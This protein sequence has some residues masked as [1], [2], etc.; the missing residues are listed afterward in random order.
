MLIFELMSTRCRDKVEDVNELLV[1]L[2]RERFGEAVRRHL[3][4][5]NPTDTDMPLFY[6]L[7]KPMVMDIN[8]FQLC[9]KR[10]LFSLQ[11]GDC[12]HVVA[13]YRC[14]AIF[15][16]IQPYV[17]EQSPPPKVVLSRVTESQ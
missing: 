8:V 13:K 3:G 11:Y 12:L 15:L 9:P 2:Y 16:E 1:S 14:V 5:G 17:F 10:R 7:A 4:S 6:F